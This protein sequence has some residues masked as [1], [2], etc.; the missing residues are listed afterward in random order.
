M[1]DKIKCSKRL[2]G[3]REGLVEVGILLNI[4]GNQHLGTDRIDQLADAPLH[5]GIGGVPIRKVREP[6]RGSFFMQLLGDR[7]GDRIIVRNPKN[8]TA[9]AIH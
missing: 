1:D 4:A 6:Q 9:L 7:P 3:C 5:L 8:E 2:F